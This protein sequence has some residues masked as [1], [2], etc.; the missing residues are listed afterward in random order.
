LKQALLIMGALALPMAVAAAPRPV[1]VELFTSEACSSCPPAE[2]LLARLKAGDPDLLPLSFHV[3]YWNGPAWTDQYALQGA[4]DRQ[5]WYAGLQNSQ[6]VYTPEAVVDGG[7]QMVGSDAGAVTAAIAAAKRTITAAVPV[8]IKDGAMVTL[9]VG[10][11]AST[12]TG[13]IWLIG[14][15]PNH[16]ARIGG[17]ENGGA[18][19][20]ETN[21][22][23]SI[24]TLGTWLGGLQSFTIPHPAGAKVAVILQQ[25]NGV[26]EGAAAD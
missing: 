13:N 6:N 7:A 25:E 4:T 14:F 8:S 2:A 21:V 15:D 20:Q 5:A 19:I 23:R 12:G 3:T 18:T 1:V 11:T 24:A 22:V 16:V 9:T 17:G 26:I 10:T